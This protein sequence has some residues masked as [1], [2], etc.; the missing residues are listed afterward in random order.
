MNFIIAVV[1]SNM[2]TCIGL[3]QM[4]KEI[5]PFADVRIFLT[6]EELVSAERC[7]IVHCFVSSRIYFEHTQ[8][9]R[10][11][12]KRTIVMVA[13]DMLINGV[14]TLNVCQN[15]HQLIKS[16]LSL[17]TMG[18]PHQHPAVVLPAA[19]AAHPPMPAAPQL[20]AREIEVARLLAK[21]HINKEVADALN[22]SITTAITHR[23]NIMDKL[24]ARSLADVII[25]A[26]TN[27]IVELGEL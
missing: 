23:K 6:F 13:G 5:I 17:H 7:N 18:H 22:I 15:E 16:I 11:R 27:G 14:I 9:F 4:L 19:P 10:E 2:L 12:H 3:Q 1:D 26:V 25:Y 20:S 24:H 21:G 8:Y